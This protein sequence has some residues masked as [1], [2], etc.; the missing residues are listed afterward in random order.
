LCDL[1]PQRPLLLIGNKT[2][3]SWSLR[4]WLLLRHFDVEFDELMLPLDTPEFEQRIAQYSPTRR[5]PAL[6]LGDECIWDSLA[7][8]ETANER[9]LGDRAWPA[10]P[11]ARAA[12]RSAAAEMHSGFGAM[13]AQLP[14]TCRRQPRAPH[15]DEAAQRDIERVQE[16]WRR[17]RQAHGDGEGFLCGPFGIVDAMF[18]PVCLRFRAYGPVLDRNAQRYMDAMLALPAMQRWLREAAAEPETVEKY[19]L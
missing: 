10:E 1:P 18:A 3:S 16:L 9:W 13:R 19:L 2:F 8:C 15:W 5:V 6:W 12:A 14:M 4:P 17:L 7:I 11:R